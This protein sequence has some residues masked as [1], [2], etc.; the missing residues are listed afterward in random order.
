MFHF[1]H[2]LSNCWSLLVQFHWYFFLVKTCLLVNL[3]YALGSSAISHDNSN[4]Y[5]SFIAHSRYNFPALNLKALILPSL[6]EKASVMILSFHCNLFCLLPFMATTSSTLTSGSLL[7]C[8]NFCFSYNY[9][10]YSLLLLFRA[11][12]FGL[13]LYFCLFFRSFW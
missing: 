13:C 12:S 9:V 6:P 11:D 2:R 7:L 5:K 4:R 3:L 8:F 1:Y 10:R